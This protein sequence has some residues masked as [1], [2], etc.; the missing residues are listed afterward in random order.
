MKQCTKCYR[1]LREDQFNKARRNKS[2]LRAECRE[3]Q[4]KRYQIYR[5]PITRNFGGG[6]Y[7]KLSI[8]GKTISEHRYIME[9]ILGRSLSE[10]EVVHHINGN[11]K[12]NRPEN[13]RVMT[14]SEHS[15]MENLGKKLSEEHKAKI[16]KSLIGNQLALGYHHTEETK[17]IIGQKSR[18]AR[19]R[20][21]W[22]SRKKSD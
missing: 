14:V 3:C 13:L 15:R 10:N 19:K 1:Y 2:G 9:N 4:I 6:R 18:E 12:D 16:S 22:S 5:G 11:R 7:L 20:K 8:G 17:K 21:F